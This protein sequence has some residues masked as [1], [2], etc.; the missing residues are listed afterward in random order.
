[1]RIVSANWFVYSTHVL[2]LLLFFFFI[3]K[4]MSGYN[5]KYI[6]KIRKSIIT[7]TPN[8][9]IRIYL[10]HGFGMAHYFGVEFSE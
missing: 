8:S 5:F 6:F 10:Q 4:S 7:L 2:V 9:I 3:V 1:M